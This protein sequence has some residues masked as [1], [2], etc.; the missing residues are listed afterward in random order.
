M[1]LNKVRIENPNKWDIADKNRERPTEKDSQG[2][3]STL[4]NE[5][6]TIS[7]FA[8]QV[9]RDLREQDGINDDTIQDSLRPF[10]NN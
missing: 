5:R 7:D 9:F 1:R 2:S 3:K 4:I 8:Y 6:V 10:I